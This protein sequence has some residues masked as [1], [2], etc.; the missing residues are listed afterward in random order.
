MEKLEE[1]EQQPFST[2]VVFGDVNGLKKENDENG[3]VAG[4]RLLRR[5]AAA[6]RDFWGDDCVYRAGGDEFV[7]LV[8]DICECTFYRKFQE[9]YDMMKG[10]A[11]ISVA[12][13][14][15]WAADGKSLLA[16]FS[17]ADRKMYED[18]KTFYLQSAGAE[19]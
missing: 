10:K 1:L 17:R 2:G 6:M 5:A 4:D 9:F 15:E 7:A 11:D 3:H 13:G 12:Y 14:A 19:Y 16:A 8:S 18:K